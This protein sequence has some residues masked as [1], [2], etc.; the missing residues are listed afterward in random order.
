M[1]SKSARSA[2]GKELTR[3]QLAYNRGWEVAD[4][5]GPG[6]RKFESRIT[7]KRIE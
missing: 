7:R 6:V 4:R 3:V 1:A 5:I 2:F